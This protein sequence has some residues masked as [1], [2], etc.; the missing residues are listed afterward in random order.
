MS[1]RQLLD[2][3]D[4]GNQAERGNN[5]E[6]RNALRIISTSPSLR[7]WPLPDDRNRSTFRAE[8]ECDRV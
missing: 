4:F 3:Y 1:N 5:G 6:K 2:K 8:D 7:R